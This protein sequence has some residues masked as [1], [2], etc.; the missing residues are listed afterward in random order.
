MTGTLPILNG[1]C[2]RASTVKS[3]RKHRPPETFTH[4][5]REKRLQIIKPAICL[6]LTLAFGAFAATP[7]AHGQTQSKTLRR[8]EPNVHAPQLYADRIK[9]KMTL[10]N[11]PGAEE[12]GSY[13]EASYQI[14]FISESNL[15]KKLENAPEGGWNP[16]PADFSGRILLGEGK[17]KRTSLHTLPERTYVSKAIPLKMKVPDKSR[18]KYASILTSYS[19]K[20]YD[21]R[22]KSNIYRSG[23][24]VAKPFTDTPAA[25]GNEA[26]RTLLHANFYVSPNGHLFYSQRPRDSAST[27]WP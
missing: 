5:S 14:F 9:I 13:W 15:K 8:V 17:L 4:M 12:P 25:G 7:P 2:A 10:I 6:C 1:H 27:T 3:V 20:I 16:T 23:T 21:A 22:L 19:V 18:T 11:L 24:F 26:A